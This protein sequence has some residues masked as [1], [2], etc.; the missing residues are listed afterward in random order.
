[1]KEKVMNVLTRM[2][3]TA[4][5]AALALAS[6]SAPASAQE[7][8]DDL[9]GHI[10]TQSRALNQVLDRLGRPDIARAV[11]D[12]ALRGD[13]RTFEGLFEGVEL[14]VPNRCVWIADTVEKLTSTFVGLEQEC[15][16][17]TDLTRGELFDYIQITLKHYPPP[18]YVAKDGTPLPA[19]GDVIPPGPYLDELRAHGLVNCALVKK[20][21]SG[22]FLFAGKPEKFCLLGRP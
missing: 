7:P 3:R 5:A 18:Q 14:Q 8:L 16:L 10:A 21:S 11:V 2:G 6:S 13:A 9:A 4:A 20:Y 19:I 15:R 17:R 22:I 1:M 12:S